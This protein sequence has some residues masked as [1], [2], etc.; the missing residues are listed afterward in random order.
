MDHFIADFGF[1]LAVMSAVG[2]FAGF[3][4]GVFGIGGGIILVPAFYY[5][6]D[7][8][9]YNEITAMHLAVATSLAV[10][11]LATFASFRSHLREEN[12]DKALLKSWGP[13][14]LI[15]VALGAYLGTIVQGLV[16]LKI[17][18]IYLFFAALAMMQCKETKPLF[19]NLPGEPWRGM[20]GLFIGG[21]SSMLGIGGGTITVP[22]MAL[23]GKPMREAIGT[24]AALSTL[25]CMTGALS[26]I[27]SGLAKGV[28]L[29]YSIGYVN[30]AAF[31]IVSPV[32]I[33]AAKL[34]ARFANKANP[35]NLRRFFACFLIIVGIKMLYDAF[36]L[37]AYYDSFLITFF[38]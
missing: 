3:L 16:L 8:L 35:N 27:V 23:F 28:D 2:L 1:I 17:F 38:D 13:T 21:L 30:W 7:F 25:I 26:H 6:F 31:M 9:G 5:M 37:A 11:V 22:K 10:S 33:L 24:A 29:P 15:G 34:G 32:G 19:K 18:A 4:S 36:E 12:V 20:T 14:I